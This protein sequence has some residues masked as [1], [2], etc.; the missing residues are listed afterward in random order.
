MNNDWRASVTCTGLSA[1]QVSG[2]CH[3]LVVTYDR[4]VSDAR[5]ADSERAVIVR[6]VGPSRARMEQ[7]VEALDAASEA[8]ED[9]GAAAADATA[10]LVAYRAP[11]RIVRD[12]LKV[13]I[14]VEKAGGAAGAAA[15]YAEVFGAGTAISFLQGAPFAVW[16]QAGKALDT[17]RGEKVS[18]ALEAHHLTGHVDR[19]EGAH[20]SFGRAIGATGSL[21]PPAAVERVSVR[22]ALDAC[23]AALCDYAARAGAL[24]DPDVPGSEALLSRLLV[25][26][27]AVP[28]VPQRATKAAAANDGSE[29]DDADEGEA[30]NDASD[31]SHTEPVT[32]RKTG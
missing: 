3:A 11:W 8:R 16:T 26:L 7:A 2:A 24:E 27:D 28:R 21:V 1:S 17:L 5:V 6:V 32:P 22:E 10:A 15:L 30:E 14:R 19:V 23:T 12:A 31:A 9:K 4:V 29:D 20:R 18:A 13:A 25:A